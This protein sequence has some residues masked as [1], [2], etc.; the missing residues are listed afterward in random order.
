MAKSAKEM[1]ESPDFKKL[2]STRWSVSIVLLILLF[3][4]Y[5]GYIMLIAYNHE[6]MASKINPDGV[7]TWGIPLGVL[8]IVLA[9]ILTALYVVWANTKYDKEVSRLKDLM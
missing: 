5:Y 2:V 7:T 3:V 1:M 8:T 6:F 4:V 9:W